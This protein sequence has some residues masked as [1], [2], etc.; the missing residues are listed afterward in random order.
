M[1]DHFEANSPVVGFFRTWCPYPIGDLFEAHRPVVSLIETHALSGPTF[2]PGF[3]G[4][5]CLIRAHYVN[6]FKK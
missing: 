6:N 1:G 3:I 2:P 4:P 5:L